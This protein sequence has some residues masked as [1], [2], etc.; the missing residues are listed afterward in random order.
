MAKG[1]LIPLWIEIWL[2]VS[3]LLCAADVF[4]TMM[5]PHTLRG[6]HLSSLYLPWHIYSDVDL[7]YADANDLVTMA[8]G[9][10]MLIEIVMNVVAVILAR[11][12]S[13]HAI[14]TTFTTCMLVFWKT[15]LYMVM[16]I[17]QPAGT[18]TYLAEEA[19]FWKTFWVF[20][21]ADG[22]WVVLPLAAAV[23]LWP[24]LAQTVKSSMSETSS[25]GSL[26]PRLETASV[27]TLQRAMVDYT[28]TIYIIF[29]LIL[30][31]Q[32]TGSNLIV[33]LAYCR[34][35]HLR[36]ITNTYIFSLACTDFLA[37]CL[38]IP[39]TVY[40][41]LT[42]APH[43]FYPCLAI[44]LLLCA[45]CTISTFHLLAIAVDKYLSIC[46]K[47][48]LLEHKRRYRRALALLA[49]AWV[50]GIVI[51]V[52]PMFNLFGFA[53]GRHNYS[54]LC[55][56]TKVVH[57]HYLV[58]VI[59]FGTIILPTFAIIFCYV[60][61][62]R[63]IWREEREVRTLLRG[64]ERERR[65]RQRKGIIR[66]LVLVVVAFFFCWYPLYTINS[67]HFFFPHLHSHHAIT[68]SAVVMS[69]LN[70]GLN[71]VIYAYGLPGFKQVLRQR[72]FFTQTTA[73]M[74]YAAS[75]YSPTLTLRRKESNYASTR[76][77]ALNSPLSTRSTPDTADM[78]RQKR[79]F[80]HDS[81]TQAATL[82]RCSTEPLLQST[83]V[84]LKLNCQH[85]SSRISM[86]EASTSRSEEADV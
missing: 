76:L 24:R 70:C 55:H 45:L 8:T 27:I 30:S 75:H 14:V 57:Y 29:E 3:S 9:R 7:R 10:V 39:L 68:L 65:L 63:T 4:Y 66:S 73:S 38:G 67:I 86:L 81:A 35:I 49:L 1:S 79:S 52:M 74:N 33:L 48:Q 34:S 36:T 41:V 31:I 50:F 69:H 47:R 26:M 64:K 23:Q 46:C 25:A 28:I 80:I 85:L 2:V 44:H 72:S 15:F 84:I 43:S 22:V 5:R 78:R 37:G 32:I 53:D 54:G 17:N 83:N 40:S 13:P 21:V 62:Y 16:Y 59:F 56:F 12:R 6:G 60:R 82:Q 20:W 71:P 51:G 61:I 19:G 42:R 18:Q 58:F 11:R 77:R